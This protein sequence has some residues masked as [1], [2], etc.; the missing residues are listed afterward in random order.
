MFNITI[1]MIDNNTEYFDLIEVFRKNNLNR[2][3]FGLFII[4]KMALKHFVL[5]CFLCALIQMYRTEISF[6]KIVR[7]HPSPLP[8][9]KSGSFGILCHF[10]KICTLKLNK[11]LDNLKLNN[12]T[13]RHPLL[14]SWKNR[15]KSFFIS[16]HKVSEL[17]KNI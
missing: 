9:T 7:A 5:L 4:A 15:L 10:F 14:V 12:N 17:N 13:V 2:S 16:C 6:R 3:T 1:C 11:K 8:N